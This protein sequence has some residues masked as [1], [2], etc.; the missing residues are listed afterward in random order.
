MR[1]SF[2]AQH[3][4]YIPQF[5]PIWQ[6]LQEKG[7]ECDV[8]L[9]STDEIDP[10]IKTVRPG[11]ELPNTLVRST[12]EALEHY[13]KQ[14]PDW[15]V[16]GNGFEQLEALPGSIK[17]A[18]VNHGAGIKVAGY[19]GHYNRMDVRFVEGT[20]HL[21]ALRTD[22]PD[23]NFVLA[24]FS[25]LDPLIAGKQKPLDLAQLGLDSA[26]PVVLYAPTFYPSSIELMPKDLPSQ[27]ADFNLVIKPHYF[28][29]IKKHYRGQR[30]LLERW[31]KE[32]NVYLAPVSDYSL[33]PYLASASILIS[34]ASTTLFEAAVA[35][36]PI[37]W[38]DF[39][40]LRWNY[41]GPFRYRYLR[42]LDPRMK[43]YYDIAE[44]VARPRDLVAA[45]RHQYAARQSYAEKR[46]AYGELL[47]GPCDGQASQRICD[48]LLAES[49][50]RV[51]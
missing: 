28:T 32:S 1:V 2:D 36:I 7:V 5:Q 14:L 33:L 38:C 49:S 45:I 12:E 35:D 29:Y 21:E 15:I 25:K 50:L 37:V 24:G 43:Q 18:M 27:L 19:R 34:E 22:Y 16:F 30:R 31:N 23:R 11:L 39:V 42:R 13:Q 9:Y 46:K 3:L 20:H 26:K 44:H 10:I 41:R 48:Y 51:E 40:K 17:T 4:Y 6:R 47:L 8:V